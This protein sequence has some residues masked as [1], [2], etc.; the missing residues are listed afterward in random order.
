[1]KKTKMVIIALM[2]VVALMLSSCG[3]SSDDSSGKTANQKGRES[4]QDANKSFEPPDIKNDVE[5]H[6]YKAAQELYDDPSSIIWCTTTWGNNSAPLVTVPIS[7]KLTSSSVSLFPSSQTKI[8]GGGSGSWN[9]TYNQELPSVD[10]MFHGSPP[11][12]RYGFTPGGQYVDFFNMP[13]FCTTALTAFQRES[14]KVVTTI[15]GDAD[16]AQKKA[17]AAIAKC[18]EGEDRQTT[19]TGEA[20]PGAQAAIDAVGGN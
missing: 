1:M 13:T 9:S 19:K 18:K 20:C 16:D 7:G 8:G 12:Y 15:D 4:S 14:T 5:Y 6:N 2:A 11:P 17:E 10:A 3:G